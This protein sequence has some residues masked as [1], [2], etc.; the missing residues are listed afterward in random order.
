[1][2]GSS[3]PPLIWLNVFIFLSS[4]IVAVAVVPWYGMTSGYGVEH[5]IWFLV[6][7]SFC[8]LSITAGYHRLWSHKTY[9]AHW[10]L[11]LLFALGGAFA[12]QNSALHWSSDHRIHH[13]HVDNNDKDPYSAKRG[14]WFSHI[15][16][17]LREYNANTFENYSNCRDL[18]KDKIVMW[19]HKYYVPL[20]IATNFGIPI[21]LGLLHGDVLGMLLIV[22]VL[23]LVLSHHS[24]FFINSLAHIWG[25]QPYTDKNTARDNAVLAVFTFGEGYHN[26]HHIFENDYR[27]GIYWWQYDPTKWLIKSCSWFGLTKKLRVTPKLIIEKAKAKQSLSTASRNISKLP[28][29]ALLNEALNKEFEA[30]MGKMSDYY[31]VKKQVLEA[32]KNDLAKKYEKSLLKL[33]YQQMKQE[34]ATQRKSWESMV[35]QYA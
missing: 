24:T 6:A 29:A 4:F 18:Q 27:N 33:R 22:G 20:A 1:M 31:D 13:K 10:S 35:A 14:F 17:M 8:N 5:L 16:W 26:Y 7:F 12:L 11:R 34:L 9:E 21:A 25:S 19:Q 3:K 2:S 23:R 30:L 15:G 28:N 32:K